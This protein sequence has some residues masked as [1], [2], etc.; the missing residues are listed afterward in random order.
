MVD[1]LAGVLTGS[2]CSY[3]ASMFANEEG[4]PPN[5]GQTIIAMDPGF[6]STGYLAHLESMLAALTAGNTVRVPGQRR[7]D[8]RAKHT[9]F[10]V[11]V[12]QSLLDTIAEL[13]S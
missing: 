9:E 1:L 5:V 4:G 13:S 6:F 2:N 7:G 11:E 12:P 8:L 3:E 10:G